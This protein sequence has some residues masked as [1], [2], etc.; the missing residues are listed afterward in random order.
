MT[1][2]ARQAPVLQHYPVVCELSG[3]TLE[4]LTAGRISR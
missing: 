3:G 4:A 2:E 1:D